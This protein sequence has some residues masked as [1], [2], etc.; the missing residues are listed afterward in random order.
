MN[1]EEHLVDFI[2]QI[3]DERRL[4]DK[5]AEQFWNRTRLNQIGTPTY[6]DLHHLVNTTLSSGHISGGEITDDAD[7]TITV[8]AGTG[9]IKSSAVSSIED[10]FSFDWPES[11]VVPLVNN[12]VNYIYVEYNAGTPRAWSTTNRSTIRLSDQFTLGRVYKEN[13]TLHIL[14][15][16]V[17]LCNHV[18]T[19]HERL[20]ACRWIEHA[21]GGEVSEPAA[22]KVKVTAGV[23]YV[24]ANKIT[25][26]EVDTSVAGTFTA[27]YRDGVGDWTKELAQTDVN[28]EKYDDGDGVLGD[29]PVGRYSARYVYID[30]DGHIF[31]QYGQAGDKLAVIQGE[32]V[33]TTSDFLNSFAIL[34][35]RI[36]VK[37]GV[38]PV[39]EIASAFVNF[40]KY[41]G[42]S[43]HNDLAN[44][45]GGQ[46]DQ[47]YHLNAAEHGYVSGY[48][49]G[50]WTPDLRFDGAKV[51]ITYSVVSGWYTK[52]GRQVTITS[53]F[54]LT[55]KGTSVGSAVIYGLP[56]TVAND[57]AAYV[58]PSFRFDN[59]TFANIFQGYGAKNSTYI[60]LE[61]IT[62][63]GVKSFIS[64]VNFA[65]N[66]T[67]M[68]SC[69]YFI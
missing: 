42:I 64:N 18:R 3:Q 43:D 32:D 41:E 59:I 30:L 68:I 1:L 57:N 53:Y 69:T 19:N 6:S 33:P 16:G 39:T 15:S 61:E 44:L 5:R 29:I 63:A 51:G 56:F 40:F 48:E 45:Q 12:S 67:L 4:G 46:A 26:A 35:A 50:I 65:D 31:I 58:A 17:H 21:S 20:V 60:V 23:F 66:S 7:G 52:I 13:N 47:Y 2:R 55:S 62:E 8:A 37:D 49:E 36:I 34:A 28:V 27:I 24:G 9:F 11:T 38:S 14:N 54:A 10:T 25:T 22:L